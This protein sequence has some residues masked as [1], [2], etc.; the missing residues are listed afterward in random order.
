MFCFS[1]LPSKICVALSFLHK[2][3]PN[4][5]K[6]L[7]RVYIFL[8]S[9]FKLI[10]FSNPLLS[11]LKMQTLIIQYLTYIKAPMKPLIDLSTRT[12]TS[13]LVFICGSFLF[14]PFP[15]CYEPL[16]CLSSL[17]FQIITIIFKKVWKPLWEN[18]PCDFRWVF[19]VIFD[20]LARTFK[21]MIFKIPSSPAS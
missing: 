16:M 15:S 9:Y 8:T 13:A 21:S 1:P 18:I 4:T 5:K 2:R 7:K 12:R 6:I 20:L 17:K 10:P 19:A 14:P 11:L 3:T